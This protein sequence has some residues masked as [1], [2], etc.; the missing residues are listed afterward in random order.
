MLRGAVGVALIGLAASGAA[1]AAEPVRIGVLTESWGFTA[2]AAG[3]RDGL[4]ALG[5]RENDDF[6]LGV[7][8]TQGDQTALPAA[9]V[10]L[11][12]DGV[13]VLFVEEAGPAKAA[14]AA[15]AR[16]P[17]IL[18]GVADPVGLGLIQSFTR[19]GGNVTG[20]TDLDIAIGP[21]RLEIFRDM[22]PALRRVLL[23]YAASD[24]YSPAEV[25]A[26]G[27]AAQQ[28]G[29][30]VID[31]ALR[32]Q[33]EARAALARVRKGEGDGSFAPHASALNIP[34]FVLEAAT[35]AAIPAIFGGAFWVERGG[36]ASYG[37]D[38]EETGRQAARVL[39]KILK[40]A[41]P[42]TVPVE[43]NRKVSFVISAKVARAL[44]VTIPQATLVRA[45]RI[46]D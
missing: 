21:K 27:G 13:D 26:V 17:I 43:V 2:G 4:K 38:Y 23:P 41:A 36:F 40:G 12:R 8:F 45:T 7:R 14:R 25:K 1:Q 18:G 30:V 35:R 33:D 5:Y 3:L 31:R 15:T 32:R 46:V 44:G 11:V 37:P 6:V 9:A 39:Q 16:I 28:L 29:I 10:E 34:G 22:V 20:V 19:P 24:P 42:A